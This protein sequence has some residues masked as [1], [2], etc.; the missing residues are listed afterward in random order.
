MFLKLER[1][2]EICISGSSPISYQ[3][4]RSMTE[5]DNT[6]LERT[7]LKEDI[8]IKG[9]FKNCNLYNNTLHIILYPKDGLRSAVNLQK[10]EEWSN[11]TLKLQKNA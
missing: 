10:I 6:S 9:R 7:D 4:N 1:F 11:I 2:R 3:K 5:K 8:I